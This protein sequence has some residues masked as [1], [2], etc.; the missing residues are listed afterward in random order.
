MCIVARCY[1]KP[2][3]CAVLDT[4]RRFVW[5]YVSAERNAATLQ[6]R[7]HNEEGARGDGQGDAGGGS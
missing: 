1:A 5:C 2:R 3:G 4:L 6:R 7:H